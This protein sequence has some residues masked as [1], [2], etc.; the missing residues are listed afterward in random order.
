MKL[1]HLEKSII[2]M[3]KDFKYGAEEGRKT[4]VKPI[5]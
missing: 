3:F 4:S 2:H 1:G 5:V